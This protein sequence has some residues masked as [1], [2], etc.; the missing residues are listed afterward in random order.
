M[1]AM[2][3]RRGSEYDDYSVSQRTIDNILNDRRIVSISFIKSGLGIVIFMFPKTIIFRS[4]H[5][6]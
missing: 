4:I 3:K 2:K 6:L 5:N 1:I